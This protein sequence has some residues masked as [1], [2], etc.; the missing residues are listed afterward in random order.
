MSMYV[1]LVIILLYSLDPSSIKGVITI[2]EGNCWSS[3]SIF[4]L[5]T[6]DCWYTFLT[7]FPEIILFSTL[8]LP[9]LI[10]RGIRSV[11]L[12]SGSLGLDHKLNYDI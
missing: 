1:V 6:I 11:F 12:H 5:L 9:L 7:L 3:S 8:F 4:D 2:D 10:I